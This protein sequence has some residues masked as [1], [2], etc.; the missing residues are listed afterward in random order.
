[1]R[2]DALFILKSLHWNTIPSVCMER[3]VWLVGSDS[4]PEEARSE[5]KFRCLK[6]KESSHHAD[7][8]LSDT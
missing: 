5:V 7:E 8:D 6:R 4:E 2:I 1:M 3:L